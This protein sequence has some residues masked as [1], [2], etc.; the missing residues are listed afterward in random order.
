MRMKQQSYFKCQPM[1]EVCQKKL[2]ISF[3]WV[4]GEW[5]FTC[6]CTSSTE[7]Y[8]VYIED[9]FASTAAC[10]FRF[11]ELS[12]K[13]WMDWLSFGDMIYRFIDAA[14]ESVV[15]TGEHDGASEAEFQKN[16]L[17]YLEGETDGA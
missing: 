14:S 12:R 7:M 5:K 13:S 9:F 2:A 6:D 17:T 4:R 11:D 10:V 16:C 3:S 8:F 1:C 15:S